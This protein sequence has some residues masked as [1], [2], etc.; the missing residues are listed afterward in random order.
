ML[1]SCQTRVR[2]EGVKPGSED[3]SEGDGVVVCVPS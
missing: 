3:N 1:F 2:A